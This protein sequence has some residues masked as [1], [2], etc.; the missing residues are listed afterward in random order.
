MPCP[1]KKDNVF[2][3]ASCVKQYDK[4]KTLKNKFDSSL[5]YIFSFIAM[6]SVTHRFRAFF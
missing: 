4:I 2:A 6:G 3:R 5:L 1:V